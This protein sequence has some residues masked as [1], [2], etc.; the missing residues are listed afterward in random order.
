[1]GR[2]KGEVGTSYY[3]DEEEDMVKERNC[4]T[5]CQF[6]TGRTGVHGAGEPMMAEIQVNVATGGGG[7]QV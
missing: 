5:W 1:M 2:G 6:P 3:Q 7:A 4:N